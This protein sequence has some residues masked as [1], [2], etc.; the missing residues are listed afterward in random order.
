MTDA[1]NYFHSMLTLGTS[2]A[3]SLGRNDIRLMRELMKEARIATQHAHT[4]AQNGKK[5]MSLVGDPANRSIVN[6]AIWHYETAA[7]K[8]LQAAEWLEQACRLSRQTKREIFIRNEVKEVM[9]SATEARAAVATLKNAGS[10]GYIPTTQK[11]ARRPRLSV[12]AAF[13]TIL[14]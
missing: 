4:E 9:R 12:V 10:K 8:Y 5:A 6:I 3:T 11:A 14:G 1:I 2:N 7:Q 13:S